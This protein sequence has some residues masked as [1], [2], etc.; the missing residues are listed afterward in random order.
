MPADKEKQPGVDLT[1][2]REQYWPPA[3]L[4]RYGELPLF[5]GTHEAVRE[6]SETLAQAMMGAAD[7]IYDKC[8]GDQP[9]WMRVPKVFFGVER[10]NLAKSPA[11]ASKTFSTVAMLVA[12]CGQFEAPGLAKI[13]AC[14]DQGDKVVV[15]HRAFNDIRAYVFVRG[16]EEPH[17]VRFY[18]SG[19]VLAVDPDFIIQDHRTAKRR[20]RADRQKAPLAVNA[21]G[22]IVYAKEIPKKTEEK[23]P[24]TQLLP[25]SNR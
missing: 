17:R 6:F 16:Q 13:K 11:K 5:T 20:Q 18:E 7:H 8:R 23:M 12:K 15:A 25:T 24:V 14:L 4:Q 1:A 2:W 3:H 19:L 22:W 9:R 10:V 21:A